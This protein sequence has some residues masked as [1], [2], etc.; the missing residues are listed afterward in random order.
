MFGKIKNETIDYIDTTDTD[1]D[2]LYDIYE[3]QGLLWQW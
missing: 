3:K 2:G 1:G